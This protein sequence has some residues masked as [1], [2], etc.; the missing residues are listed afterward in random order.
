VK[1]VNNGADLPK[2]GLNYLQFVI[3]LIVMIAVPVA[4]SV[5]MATVRAG[6]RVDAVRSEMERKLNG[7]VTH[8]ELEGYKEAMDRILADVR[9]LDEKIESLDAKIDGKLAG[10]RADI[11]DILMMGRRAGGEKGG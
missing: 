9:R 6:E 3:M 11:K 10:I 5:Y 7:M 4:S 8:Q 2:I 1:P